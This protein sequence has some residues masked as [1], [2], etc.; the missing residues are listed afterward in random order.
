ME[1]LVGAVSDVL[2]CALAGGVRG[3]CVLAD[4]VAVL[5]Y[6]RIEMAFTRR[7]TLRV[8]Y[9]DAGHRLLLDE[10]AAE[11]TVDSLSFYAREIVIRALEVGAVGLVLAHNHPGGSPDA[12][13]ADL[14]ATD[15]LVRACSPL[16]IAVLDH[17]VVAE[18]GTRSLRVGT[19]A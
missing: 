18:Q 5:E 15:A 9:L 12:S 8:L 19:K 17:L 14:A 4:R 13:P 11:G 7:E 1:E 3:R 2:R 6:L 16:G 10:V